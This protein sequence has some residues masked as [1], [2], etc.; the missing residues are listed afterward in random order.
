MKLGRLEVCYIAPV[1][2]NQRRL[3]V[4]HKKV[5]ATVSTLITMALANLNVYAADDVTG[6]S[7][8]DVKNKI[9]NGGEYILE[10]GQTVG[11]WVAIVMAGF[12]IIKCIK[13]GD[14]NRVWGILTKYGM[15]LASLYLVEWLFKAIAGWFI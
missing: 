11:L 2:R 1:N 14:V 6:V 9:N 4:N 13:D 15:A 3:K 10:V 8:V 12:E 5:I 7:L